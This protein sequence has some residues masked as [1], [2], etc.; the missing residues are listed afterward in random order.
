[1]PAGGASMPMSESREES[2]EEPMEVLRSALCMRSA[3]CAACT[4]RRHQALRTGG[5][6]QAPCKQPLL[7][8]SRQASCFAGV[9][10]SLVAGHARV[11]GGHAN[12]Y[13]S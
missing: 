13:A 8:D 2:R 9:A 1:M 11:H 3:A 10:G 5:R 6:C 12:G 4:Y 7:G